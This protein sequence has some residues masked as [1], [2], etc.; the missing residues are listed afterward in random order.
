MC[1]EFGPSGERL[2]NGSL[3]SGFLA[4]PGFRSRSANEDGANSGRPCRAGDTDAETNPAGASSPHGDEAASSHDAALLTKLI[5]ERL[6]R[7][8]VRLGDPVE[9][10]VRDGHKRHIPNTG[11]NAHPLHSGSR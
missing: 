7:F 3:L 1:T 8:Q 4:L 10:G 9:R 5:A 2:A 6:A 11:H